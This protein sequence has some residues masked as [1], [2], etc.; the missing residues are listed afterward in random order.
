MMIE[1]GNPAISF[2]LAVDTNTYYQ[3]KEIKRSKNTIAFYVRRST[4]RRLYQLGL[5]ALRA[6]F[7]LGR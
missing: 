1:Q 7:D 4:P 2:P 6:L 3:S 5:L